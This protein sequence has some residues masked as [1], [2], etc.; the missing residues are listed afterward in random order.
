MSRITAIVCECCGQPIRKAAA[1][2]PVASFRGYDDFVAAYNAARH[3]AIAALGEHWYLVPG[4]SQ[5][6][7]IARAA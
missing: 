7:R 2:K 4:A 6:A 3:N 5:W 1:R